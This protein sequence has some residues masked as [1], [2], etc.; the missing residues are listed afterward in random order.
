M[1][2]A[3]DMLIEAGWGSDATHANP[4]YGIEAFKDVIH[5]NRAHSERPRVSS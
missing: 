5:F 3:N 4:R 2:V 1:I